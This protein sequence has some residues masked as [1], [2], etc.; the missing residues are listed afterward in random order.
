MGSS[1]D[2]RLLN[3]DV[4]NSMAPEKKYECYLLKTVKDEESGKEIYCVLYGVY[5]RHFERVPVD[6]DVGVRMVFRYD[7]DKLVIFPVKI[8]KWVLAGKY[9]IPGFDANKRIFMNEDSMEF[10]YKV[11]TSPL[12]E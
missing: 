3:T 6:D 4:Y 2:I 10:D 9:E 8:R 5:N 1:Q 12:P 7:M 11:A